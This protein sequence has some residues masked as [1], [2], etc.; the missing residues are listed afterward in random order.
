VI[1]LDHAYHKIPGAGPDPVM[2]ELSKHART[3]WRRR[4]RR[5]TEKDVRMVRVDRPTAAQVDRVLEL[6]NGSA[7]KHG[8]PALYD[9]DT[10]VAVL[11]V[12]GAHLVLAEWNGRTIGG[13][14]AIEHDS[15]LY[16]WAGGTDPEVYSE[17]SPYLFMLYELLAQG[18]ER[19]W[20]R[21]EFGRG[22]DEFKRQKGF[23][24]TPLWSLWYAATPE[25]VDVYR[26]R[27]AALHDGLATVQGYDGLP[28]R[29]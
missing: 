24:G 10:V 19:G 9:R 14:V 4:W 26:P 16:L 2:G 23:G 1:R 8:W 15:K 11:D 5:A 27:L 28:Q 21:I 3:E 17:V 12:P 6:T 18:V 13:F 29:V 20:E 25:Q 22:N 7:V